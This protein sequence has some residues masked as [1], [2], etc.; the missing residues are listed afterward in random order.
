MT[1]YLAPISDTRLYLDKVFHPK[2][3]RPYAWS[4][5]SQSKAPDELVRGCWLGWMIIHKAL[6]TLP[7]Y[8]ILCRPCLNMWH[9]SLPQSVIIDLAS[10]CDT[11]P[12]P[13]KWHLNLPLRFSIVKKTETQ[14]WS[15]NSQNKVPD[16]LVT[17]CWHGWMIIH[18]ALKTLPQYVTLDPTS[19]CDTCL[20]LNQLF[21]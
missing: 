3:S 21:T 16:Q 12:C 15:F 10:I 7:Q 5:N 1:L 14:A 18:K 19:I 8:V 17:N 4:P 11:W 2:E 6:D 13:N 20:Y 9:L